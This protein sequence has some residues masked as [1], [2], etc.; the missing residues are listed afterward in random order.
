MSIKLDVRDEVG[1]LEVVVLGIA[2][3]FGGR[4]H[5]GD[6][7]D[8]KSKAYLKKGAFPREKHLVEEM[9]W[10]RKTL[11]KYKVEVLRPE[12]I[13][14]LN[15][16]FA[17]DIFFVID[18]K[19]VI[20]E[21]IVDRR[22]EQDGVQHVIDKIDKADIYDAPDGVRIE[23]G[24]MILAGDHIFIGYADASDFE[25]YK[26]ARTNEA[27]VNYLKEMFPDKT[28]KAF[29]LK[30]SDIVAEEN[31]LH[32]DCCFQPVGEKS[33]LIFEDGFKY[34][35]DLEDIKD[36]FGD[37]NLIKVTRHEMYMMGCN[38]FSIAPD[39]VVSERGFIRI[40]EKLRALGIT[41]EE[42]PYYQTSKMEG[43]LRCSTMP[44]RRAY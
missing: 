33:A 14:D 7:Y 12:N 19:F 21:I 2:D 1:R 23:G 42:I 41:V 6:A 15:Q 3:S 26:V 39:I 44:L 9:E 11:Y 32:L 5:L 4:P 29:Q 40:N 18:D 43:L 31:A 24:D 34:H 8:P 38:V 20:P 13:E 37:K 10:F 16:I 22:P 17:R 27:G 30:K 36:H 35:D 28:V 25:K